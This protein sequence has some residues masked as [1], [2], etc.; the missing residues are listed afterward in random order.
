MPTSTN[1]A[2]SA[3]IRSKALPHFRANFNVPNLLT[4][5]RIIAIPAVF[6][7]LYTAQTEAT[8]VWAAY[9][10]G[11]AL[12]T[13]FF[14]G[15]LA[16]RWQLITPLG[17]IMDPVADKLMIITGLLMVMHLGYLNVT[18]VLLLTG[19]EIIVNSLRTLAGE[20]GYSI[21]SALSARIKVFAEGFG[22]GF[23]MTG[24]EYR[25][26]GIPWSEVGHWCI[27][28]GVGLALWSAARYFIDFYRFLREN[29]A[30]LAS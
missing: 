30:R 9:F 27:Y 17:K 22:I 3:P 16:R 20:Y 26:L 10:F 21:P 8:R 11:L 18:W 4:S 7:M 2:S 12:I 14:D 28:G 25:W 5:L 6:Y 23:L 24:P 15:W 1:S 19:R 13:D 29:H